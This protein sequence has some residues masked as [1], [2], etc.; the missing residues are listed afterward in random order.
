MSLEI[1]GVIWPER[2]IMGVRGLQM[3][4]PGMRLNDIKRVMVHEGKERQEEQGLEFSNIK[5]MERRSGH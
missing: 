1:G 4:F 2:M 5:R 3:A